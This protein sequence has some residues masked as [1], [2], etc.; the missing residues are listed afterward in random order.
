MTVSVILTLLYLNNNTS[1]YINLPNKWLSSEEIS[2][3]VL[4]PTALADP[5]HQRA[6]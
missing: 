5:L 3:G 4:R 6:L 1:D 2:R